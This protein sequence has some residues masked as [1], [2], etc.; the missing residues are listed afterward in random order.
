MISLEVECNHYHN[1]IA[2]FEVTTIS[3][4]HNQISLD[5]MSY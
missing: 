3:Y 2:S 5:V 4:N 1:S